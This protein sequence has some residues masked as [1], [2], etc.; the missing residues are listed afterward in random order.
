MMRKVRLAAIAKES[1]SSVAKDTAAM[2]TVAA[3]VCARSRTS[4]FLDMRRALLAVS[5]PVMKSASRAVR[6]MTPVSM[7]VRRNWSSV[8]K[9]VAGRKVPN[10]R[11]SHGCCMMNGKLA[12]KAPVRDALLVS[13]PTCRK[14]LR[15]SPSRP[16]FVANRK[17]VPASPAT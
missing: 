7:K 2:A 1:S 11:P 15:N 6:P 13:D 14:R 3:M 8:K 5:H 12:E 16:G 4:G 17:A 10:P 9:Y